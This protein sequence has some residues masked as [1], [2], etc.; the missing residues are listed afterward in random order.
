MGL[1][2]VGVRPHCMSSGDYHENG[3]KKIVLW[4]GGFLDPHGN[5]IVRKWLRRWHSESP[6]GALDD[7]YPYIK[8][9]CNPIRSGGRTVPSGT[10]PMQ[11]WGPHKN[12]WIRTQESESYSFALLLVWFADPDHIRIQNYLHVA[13][14]WVFLMDLDLRIRI[15]VRVPSNSFRKILLWYF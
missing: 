4:F 14:R 8:S 6:P 2:E 11:I 3:K 15:W 12:S 7:R 13:F 5:V 9:V 10:E 1:A